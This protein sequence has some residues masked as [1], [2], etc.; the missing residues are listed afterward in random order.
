[1]KLDHFFTTY[2][3]V[4]SEWIKDLNVRYENIKLLK[5]NTGSKFLNI[6]FGDD[7]LDLTPRA[8][9]TKSKINK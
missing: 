8:R 6:C 7:F 2:T 1:M 4:N 9:T 5:E 3:K